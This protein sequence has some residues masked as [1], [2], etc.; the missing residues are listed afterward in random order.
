MKYLLVFA[1]NQITDIIY[2]GTDFVML[3]VGSN[4]PVGTIVSFSGAT[5]PRKRGALGSS[6]GT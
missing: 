3:N 2:D 4:P 6:A 1:L 5:A